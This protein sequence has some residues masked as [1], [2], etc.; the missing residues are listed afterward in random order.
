MPCPPGGRSAA[1]SLALA[2]CLA[3][4]PAPAA[5]LQ[6]AGASVPAT[7][8]SGGQALV[9]NGAGVRTKVIVKVYAAALYATEKSSDAAALIDSDRP[10]RL[11][12][13][14][15]RDVDGKTLDEALQ[16]GLRDNTPARE[17]AALQ[18][19]AQR[20]SALMAEIGT[21]REGDVIDLDFDARGVSVAG[22]G[23]PRGR[24]DDP[25][26]ARALLRVWL[27]DKPAQA[28]LKKALLGN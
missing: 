16:D 18:A 4:G 2:A 14:L 5:D 21:V 11:R 1:L 28:S 27:G 10:R 25:V 13:R 8:S 24:I 7:V 22:N 19:P 6:I 17:L 3:A 23:Q 20:L 26:F 15:L 12:L 9:L